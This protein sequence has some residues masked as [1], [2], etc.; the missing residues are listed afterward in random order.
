MVSKIKGCI[1]PV[2]EG[3]KNRTFA[4]FRGPDFFRNKKWTGAYDA[5][6]RSIRMPLIWA[7]QGKPNA[8]GER[9][10]GDANYRGEENPKGLQLI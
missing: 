3:M 6:P 7:S 4:K 2:F 10:S 5:R 8:L 9:S 1:L